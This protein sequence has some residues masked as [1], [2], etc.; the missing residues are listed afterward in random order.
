MLR[1]RTI[2]RRTPWGSLARSSRV[3]EGASASCVPDSRG[4]RRGFIQGEREYS[5][6]YSRRCRRDAG[7]K[8]KGRERTA[9]TKDLTFWL[10]NRE[11]RGEGYFFDY[12][13][14]SLDSYLP[15]VENPLVAT[16]YFTTKIYAAIDAPLLY[17][18]LRFPNS[19]LQE[20]ITVQPRILS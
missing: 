17:R 11:G 14:R 3:C 19:G 8:S 4:I 16:R 12:R 5:V 20:F 15:S 9:R 2:L 13:R 6:L 18:A 10:I 7:K 1:E